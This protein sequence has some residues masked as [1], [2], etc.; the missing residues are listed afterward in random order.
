MKNWLAT[1]NFMYRQ[2]LVKSLASSASFGRRPDRLA[3]SMPKSAS[4]RSPP[5]SSSAPTIWGSEWSSSRAWP[6]AIRSGQKATSTPAAAGLQ[7]LGHVAGRAGIDGAA[8]DDER[9]V[10]RCGAIWSTAF[11]NTVIDGPRNSSTGVPI[12]TTRLVGPLDDRAVGAE[13]RAGRSARTLAEELVGAGLEERHLARGDPV[14]RGLADVVDADAQAGVGEGEAQGEADVAGAAEDDD[15][16]IRRHGEKV[17]VR[18]A[19]TPRADRP[20]A[21]GT[22]AESQALTQNDRRG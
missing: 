12:T 17:A 16:E 7:V 2:V 3:A 6:S 21:A 11:S 20:G 10:R 19:A 9:A 1:A 15:V 22:A 8:Q 14:E 4:A 5:R 18:C 13:S